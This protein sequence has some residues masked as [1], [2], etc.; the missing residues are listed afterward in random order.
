MMFNTKHYTYLLIL[1]CGFI[2]YL[3]HHPTLPITPMFTNQDKLIHAI[4]YAVMGV[5]AYLS[6]GK[7]T[8]VIPMLSSIMFCSIYGVTDEFHQSFIAGRVADV[9]DWLAD[10]IG[11]TLAVISMRV[12]EFLRSD[13][14]DR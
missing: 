9:W 5:L 11:A 10:T 14:R 1:Y 13:S 7:Q 3:S 6:I 2:F 12:Q 8:R 4:A